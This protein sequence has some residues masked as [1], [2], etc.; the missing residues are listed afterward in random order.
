MWAKFS[1]SISYVSKKILQAW[2]YVSIAICEHI[3][4]YVGMV[5]TSNAICEQNFLQASHMWEKN[6]TSMAICEHCNM[7]PYLLLCDISYIYITKST[8]MWAISSQI[9]MWANHIILPSQNQ[10]ICEQ[11]HLLYSIHQYGMAMFININ[12]G[13]HQISRIPPII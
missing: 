7:W 3:C 5:S 10:L 9:H 2:Q 13:F 8:N 11:Y 12:L 4:C 6:S 1:T